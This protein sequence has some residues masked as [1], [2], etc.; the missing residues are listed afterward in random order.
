MSA[1]I[2]AIHLLQHAPGIRCAAVTGAQT[3]PPPPPPLSPPPPPPLP[4]PPFHTVLTTTGHRA[5]SKSDGAIRQ[6]ASHNQSTLNPT[7]ANKACA[8]PPPPVPTHAPH[9][10][11]P[12][13]SPRPPHRE[14]A[15]WPAAAGPRHPCHLRAS[16]RPRVPSPPPPALPPTPGGSLT[17]PAS[18]PS[19]VS[20][21]LFLIKSVSG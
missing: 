12:N 8:P 9:T 2:D 17:A 10:L 11:T 18:C 14:P 4:P 7:I 21:G 5:E 16:S 1:P 19:Q 3:N 13:P 15:G 6:W 20:I